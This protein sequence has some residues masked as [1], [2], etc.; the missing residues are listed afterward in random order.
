MGMQTDVKQAHLNG[1]GFF[2]KGRNRVKGISMVG[3]GA[4]DGILV[5]FDAAAA[6]VTASVTYGR[7]GTTVTVAKTS[8]GLVSGDVIGIHFANGTGGSATDGTYT[9]TRI[10]A[11]SFSI[12][13]IN[14]G[15]ITGSPAAIY[16]VGRWLIT[17]EVDN[18][19]VFQNAPFI[20][21][22][23]VLATTAVYGYMSNIQAAQIYYG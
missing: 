19:D 15:T 7:S 18:T 11:N 22:E 9:V 23:G 17:Y 8:H 13:D 5:L 16:A 4:A 3:S 14:S 10:D 6:P 2:V 1:S 12:T 20:P 21:G